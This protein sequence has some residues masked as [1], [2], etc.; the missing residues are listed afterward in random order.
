LFLFA[1]KGSSKHD[2]LDA[3]ERRGSSSCDV[4]YRVAM[5]QVYRIARFRLESIFD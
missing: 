5:A 2:I 3:L 4:E 1:V